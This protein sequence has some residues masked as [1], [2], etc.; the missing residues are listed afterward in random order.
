MAQSSHSERFIVKTS[1]RRNFVQA[2]C[3][4]IPS[5]AFA[6]SHADQ[7]QQAQLTP[8]SRIAV[9]GRGEDRL[10]KLRSVGVSQTSFKVSSEETSGGLFVMENVI[11]KRGG[12]PLHLHHN[13]DEYFYVVE[14]DFVIEVGGQRF[15]LKAGDSI[16]GPRKVPHAYAFIGESPGRLLISYAPAN[17]MQEYFATRGEGQKYSSDAERFRAY[18]MELLGPPIKL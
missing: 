5:F 2:V 3:S 14:G 16:L 12:P 18:G 11:A 6:Q 4:A 13:E 10:G 17:K 15:N 9:V 8:G 1:K 7:V